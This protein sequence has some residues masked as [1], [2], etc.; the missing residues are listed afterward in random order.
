MNQFKEICRCGHDKDTHYKKREACLGV[1]CDCARYRDANDPP[2]PETLRG[3]PVASNLKPHADV[4]CPCQQCA[5]WFWAQSK[6]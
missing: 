4:W 3:I 6:P 1:H 5:D 2:E